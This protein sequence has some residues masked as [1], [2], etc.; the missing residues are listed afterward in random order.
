M[1]VHHDTV[2][3]KSLFRIYPDTMTRKR[4]GK[5]HRTLEC[6]SCSTKFLS[7]RALV[8]HIRQSECH[9]ETDRLVKESDNVA[10]SRLLS[11]TDTDRICFNSDTVSDLDISSCEGGDNCKLFGNK[12]E[13]SSSDESDVEFADRCGK[14]YSD[15]DADDSYS[16]VRDVDDHDNYDDNSD[17]S[18]CDFPDVQCN[19][20]DDIGM[21][22]ATTSAFK[23]Q[24]SLLDLFNKS[25]ASL[26]L[27]DDTIRLFND[28][29]SAH[30]F[31]RFDP[32]LSRKQFIA[33]LEKNYGSCALKP[34]NGNVR[35]HDG[36]F[37]TVPVFEIK[38]MILSILNDPTLM[39]K[40][41]FVEGYDIF[42]GMVDPNHPAND[43]YGEIH[44][45]DVWE[46][47]RSHYCD[48]DNGET[49]FMPLALIIFGDK[50]HTDLHGS[51][52]V[53]PLIFTLSFFNQQAR[54]RTEF[55]RPLGYVP[56]LSYGKGDADKTPPIVK[57]QNEH[58]CLRYVLQSVKHLAERRLQTT[59]MGRN[60]VCTIWI[61][62]FIG[63][64]EGNNKWLGH[65]GGNNP[66]IQQPY[67]DCTC[68]FEDLS[69]TNPN[70]EY[71]TLTTI[72]N[73]WREM[74]IDDK[75]G[76]AAFKLISKH[77]IYNAFVDPKLPLS[78]LVH[79]PYRMTPPE[80]LHTSSSGLI[81]NMLESLQLQMGKTKA[82]HRLD[83]LHVRLFNVI[84]R[85]SERDYPRGAIRNGIIDSTRS[86]SSERRGNFFMLM[87]IA[88]TVEGKHILSKQ[89]GLGRRH[90]KR[91][92]NFLKN[93]LAMEEWF[94]HSPPKEEVNNAREAI[95]DVLMELQL[96][97][98][99]AEDTNGYNLPKMHGMTK[100]QTYM[101]LYGSAINFYGGPGESAHKL[102]VKAPGS[103]TQRRMREFTKQT[104]EQCYHNMTIRMAKTAL[105]DE[106]EKLY[107]Q[108]GYTVNGDIEK[109]KEN[110]EP[111]LRSQYVLSGN[112][113][114]LL[115]LEMGSEHKE[116]NTHG[117]PHS[118]I[119]VIRRDIQHLPVEKQ[120]S[121][122][123]GYRQI[124]LNDDGDEVTY[125]AHPNTYG[126]PWYDWAFVY[127]QN[128]DDK[129]EH[130][131]SRLLGF[132]DIGNGVEAV[133][134][135]SKH[136]VQW[137][138]VEEKF[139]VRFELCVNFAVSYLRVPLLSLVY[140][141]CVIEDFGS[142]DN[143][144]LIVL[145]KRR[146]GRFFGKFITAL[147]EEDD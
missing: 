142:D 10:R 76:K 89:L 136:P 6:S 13:Q 35:L 124:L 73:A 110:I 80:L 16:L 63:D 131:P 147:A 106:E 113:D 5:R 38:Q 36:S 103:K 1:S 25:K 21:R 102:F 141:L 20:F 12:E 95:S 75:M 100:I 90:W 114:S 120:P 71:I 23:L 11:L 4:P 17:S 118:L 9:K 96:F 41:N 7:H 137:D 47:A 126:R 138:L 79:G 33:V 91:W 93:Y 26:Q 42:T 22:P 87:C 146:W 46:N 99:R 115:E 28:Y 39:K 127:F 122:V 130:Y 98:P 88:H 97:F 37:A 56:N 92:I 81:Q 15:E 117:L 62:Y 111:K 135:C 61:H 59:V 54:N 86:Q 132:V 119:R 116:I 70:C 104:A 2:G 72:K 48:N 129:E 8:S 112:L 84:R 44:T 128:N 31:N 83:Q 101:K 30:D 43:V 144:Y 65:Y 29:T 139:F 68:S 55:W 133:V 34:K 105:I 145:P 121:K 19:F 51:L 94:H 18:S 69:A 67:R 125:Y 78:D 85:Q 49:V 107:L 57:L 64:T 140:P 3:A 66:G 58:D 45:G 32:L 14:Y 24:L 82:R 77:Y 134:Q 40:E 52:A 53:T 143:M 123:I 108:L 50:S 27:Y 74:Q 60:V 109:T